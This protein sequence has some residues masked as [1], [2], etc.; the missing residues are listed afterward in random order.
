[1][2]SN[3]PAGWPGAVHPPA[4]DGFEAS[5]VA[6]ALDL[7]PYGYREQKHV[8]RYP[9]ALAAMAHHHAEAVVEGARQGYRVIRA[10]LVGQMPTHEVDAVL[11]AYRVEGVKL[12]AAARASALVE[13]ALREEAFGRK[14]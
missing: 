9:V 4:S 5:A 3:V 10:E 1:M 7:L 12:A 11:E 6:W 2:T 8:R 14:P 13:C